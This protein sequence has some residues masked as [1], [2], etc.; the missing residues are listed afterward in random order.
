MSTPATIPPAAIR[1]ADFYA[2]LAGRKCWKILEYMTT[3]DGHVT[4]GEIARFMRVTNSAALKQLDRLVG[5]GLLVRGDGSRI[6]KLRPGSKPDPAVPQL[7]FGHALLRFD[8][9]DPQ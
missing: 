7:E 1:R 9:P 8:Q 5:I 3:G 2:A 4:A 6:Y